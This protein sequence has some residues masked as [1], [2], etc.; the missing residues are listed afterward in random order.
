MVPEMTKPLQFTLEAAFSET[1]K[2]LALA[3]ELR[4][5]TAMLAAVALRAA[6]AGHLAQKQK[7]EI[8]TVRDLSDEE[9]DQMLMQAAQEAGLTITRTDRPKN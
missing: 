2:V 9:L 4:N 1:E 6:L 8:R 5:P 7:T 3:F